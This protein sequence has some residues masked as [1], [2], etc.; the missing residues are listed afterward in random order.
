MAL[1]GYPFIK[2]NSSILDYSE[3]RRDV[4]LLKKHTEKELIELLVR[5]G[6]APE[7]IEDP[8]YHEAKLVFYH[9]EKDLEIKILA[10]KRE[11]E[12]FI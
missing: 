6:F 11:E 9:K 8:S 5:K 1:A 4:M 2:V 3:Y 12:T 10:R 7:K